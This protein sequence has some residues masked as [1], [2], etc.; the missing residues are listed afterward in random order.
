VFASE[1]DAPVMKIDDGGELGGRGRGT[2]R[3]DDGD[4]NLWHEELH[5]QR[6]HQ[7]NGKKKERKKERPF[8]GDESFNGGNGGNKGDNFGG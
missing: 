7:P 5:E 8:T 1:E 4:E 3:S 6:V 2:A